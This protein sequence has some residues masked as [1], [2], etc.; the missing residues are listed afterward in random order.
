MKFVCDKCSAKY[1]ISDSKVRGK[2]LKIKCKGC[3]NIIEVRDPSVLG[4]DRGGD[5]RASKPPA[6]A[7]KP[8][9]SSVLEDRFA[10]S[11]ESGAAKPKK[12][13]P[14]LYEA[15]KRS[16]ETIGK[17][18]VDLVRWFVAIEGKPIGPT[19]ARTV[20]RHQKAGRVGDDNLVWKEGMP[21]WTPLRHCKELV[22]LLA[23]LDL[24][25][26]LAP[27][28][29]GGE[30]AEPRLGLFAE[31]GGEPAESPLRGRGLGAL[32]ARLEAPESLEDEIPEAP[33]PSA[34]AGEPRD[35]FS[36]DFAAGMESSLS[37]IQSISPPRPAGADLMVKV[38]AVGFFVAAVGVLVAV[39]G[40]ADRGR[41]RPSP[42]PSRWSR[43]RSSRRRR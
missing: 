21:D 8:P 20:F 27:P 36:D 40:A 31:K 25:Q 10:E 29:E 32:D 41:W 2:I 23:R 35:W 38:A 26:S 5:D 37:E 22:G 39:F 15:V 14:G 7:D 18:E 12:G 30:E 16:A 11:F 4:S 3:G 19:S 9:A 28:S 33:P 42:R 17:D 1:T 24:E 13:T 34:G 43:R 6:S